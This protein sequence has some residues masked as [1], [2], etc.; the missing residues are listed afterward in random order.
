MLVNDDMHVM[1]GRIRANVVNIHV[2]NIRDVRSQSDE[3][4]IKMCILKLQ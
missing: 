4:V 3:T 2:T 1:V